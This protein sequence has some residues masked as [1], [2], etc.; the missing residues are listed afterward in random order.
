[1]RAAQQKNSRYALSEQIT[2]GHCQSLLSLSRYTTSSERKKMNFF[3]F[4][5]LHLY[6]NESSLL[7]Y[8]RRHITTERQKSVTEP[9]V[10]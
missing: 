3:S 5:L 4:Y 7:S 1:M 6:E 8:E 2:I 10:I 9:V